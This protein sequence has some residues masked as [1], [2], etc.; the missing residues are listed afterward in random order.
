MFDYKKLIRNRELRIKMVN[1]L[2]FIPTEPYLKMAY[3]IKSGKH[4]NLKNPV[5]YCDKLNWL[6]LHD[7]RPEYTRMADKIAVRDYIK[8]VLGQDI[9][10][11]M[12]GAWAHYDEIDFDALPSKFVL[13]CNHDSGSATVITDKSK[14]DHATLREFYEGRLR[15]NPY[16]LAREYPY[17]D[18]PPMIYAEKYM[19]PDGESDINDYKFLCFSGKPE[20]MFTITDRHSDC[21]QDFFD[22]EFNHLPIVGVYP[23]SSK[24]IPKPALFDE[25]KAL[26]TK[27]SQG[28][29]FVR[30]DLYEIGGK[31][32]FGE[33]THFDA[34]GFWPKHPDEWEY[35]L[36]DL[37]DIS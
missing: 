6:K 37:I 22:M 3:W 9:C 24:S 14:M 30:I 13:K 18:I 10:F 31:I 34:G 26:A 28:M 27:L 32:Y 33:F 25:M 23:N 2:R 1:C 15:V 16:V 12:L 4:L 7:I 19:I 5:T 20:V 35:K 29:R 17:R 21:S 36:G 8:E 11:P